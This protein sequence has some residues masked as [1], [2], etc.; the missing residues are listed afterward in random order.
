MLFYFITY[1]PKCFALVATAV[2]AKLRAILRN[3]SSN[4]LQFLCHFVNSAHDAELQIS[5]IPTFNL[6]SCA[7]VKMDDATRAVKEN[8]SWCAVSCSAACRTAQNTR[9][10]L[11]ATSDAVQSSINSAAAADIPDFVAVDLC[12][13]S[14]VGKTQHP[15]SGG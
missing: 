8:F 6:H 3:K 13:R 1:T 7:V 5:D 10:H 2:S 12:A 11:A 9:I 4:A 15:A 14:I